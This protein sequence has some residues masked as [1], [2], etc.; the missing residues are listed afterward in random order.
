M[1]RQ[2][3]IE[4]PDALHHVRS[5]GNR[6]EAIFLDDEDRLD[7]L[8]LLAEGCRHYGWLIY[9]WVLMTNHFHLAVETP[10]PNLA[11]GM[12]W[13]LGT[14]VTR[15]NKRHGLTGHL[16]GDRYHSD[17]VQSDV[18]LTRLSRY[19]VLNP[20]RAKMVERPEDYR[21]SS[22]RATAGI[23]PGP[24]WLA[25]GRLGPRF[26]EAENWQGNYRTYVADSIGSSERLWNNLTNGI[27]LGSEEWLKGLRKLVESKLLSDVHPHTHRKVGR[28]KMATI[29]EAVAGAFDTTGEEVRNERGGPARKI[30]AWLGWYE[31]LHQLRSIAAA[32]RMGSG[33]ASNLVRECER[34]LTGNPQMLVRVD[35][36]FAALD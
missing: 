14:Y 34:M 5:R 36:A 30:A 12:R 10:I 29:I 7:F 1:A 31:G 26:G 6:G 35:L 16:L 21:W 13:L 15:F 22:Y 17:L 32:L 18:Y 8:A 11:D 25:L 3:R 4:Y 19:L 23:E 27:Y 9:A 33:R 24:E 2:A 28:P 20:V